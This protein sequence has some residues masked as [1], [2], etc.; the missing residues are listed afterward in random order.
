[1]WKNSNIVYVEKKLLQ[2]LSKKQTNKLKAHL[3]NWLRDKE[4]IKVFLFLFFLLFF[5]FTFKCI[6]CSMCD[7]DRLVQLFK[8]IHWK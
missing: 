5:S 1:M 3:Q 7:L 6:A 4:C 8:C 2:I